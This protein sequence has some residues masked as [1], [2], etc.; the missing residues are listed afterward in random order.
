MRNRSCAGEGAASRSV[1]IQDAKWPFKD[2][3]ESVKVLNSE[4]REVTDWR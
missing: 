4:A 3:Q 2:S 1:S